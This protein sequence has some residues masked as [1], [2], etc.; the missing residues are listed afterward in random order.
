MQQSQKLEAIGQLAGGIAHDFNNL[1][2]VVA[3]WADEI[4][5]DPSIAIEA[6]REI[7]MSAERGAALTRQLLA[8]ARKS[9]YAPRVLDVNQVIRGLCSML[10]RLV[11]ETFEIAV[12]LA[13]SL[14]SVEVD[15]SMVEQN[16]V[17]LVLNARDS[18]PG[19]GRIR[20]PLDGV[21]RG[22]GRARLDRGQRLRARYVRDGCGSGLRAFT[23]KAVG[24]GTGLGL[25]AVYGLTERMGGTVSLDSAP[26]TEPS[27][28]STFRQRLAPR[29]RSS[30]CRN[31]SRR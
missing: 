15:P 24:E 17:N 29:L 4:R 6:S 22:N 16:L 9:A 27:S 8:F 31:P 26:G 21:R 7:V 11:G 5:A 30:L 25:A 10:E 2:T 23:T 13:Q 12:D 19:G 14:P 1:L 28:A 20:D 18:M 3:G